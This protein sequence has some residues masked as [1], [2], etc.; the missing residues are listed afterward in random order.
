MV[1]SNIK[2]GISYFKYKSFF[3]CSILI[4]FHFGIDCIIM[5]KY[6]FDKSLGVLAFAG[7]TNS[8]YV[9]VISSVNNGCGTTSGLA[10]CCF[11]T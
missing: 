3:V 11:C 4:C 5:A 10:S 8:Y 6:P 9:D 7:L 1:P 2:R